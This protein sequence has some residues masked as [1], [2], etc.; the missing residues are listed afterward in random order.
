MVALLENNQNADG[1]VNIPQVLQKYLG[2]V[3]K[4]S[5]KP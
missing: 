3:S 1:T 4:L 2:G 5:L